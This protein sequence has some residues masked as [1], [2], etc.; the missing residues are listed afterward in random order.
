M[1]IERARVKHK[2]QRVEIC[3]RQSMALPRRFGIEAVAWGW[4]S[5][6][7]HHWFLSA[8]KD[9]SRQNT[10]FIWTHWNVSLACQLA[11][12]WLLLQTA[13]PSVMSQRDVTP[14]TGLGQSVCVD[15]TLHCSRFIFGH[16]RSAVL[17]GSWKQRAIF[18]KWFFCAWWCTAR[19][20]DKTINGTNMGASKS[21][22]QLR[23]RTRIFCSWSTLW[24]A[25]LCPLISAI[26]SPSCSDP[27]QRTWGK[28]YKLKWG[29]LSA[30]A[31]A[32]I[33]WQK[34][35]TSIEIFEV[36]LAQNT[37]CTIHLHQNLRSWNR[38]QLGYSI[39]CCVTSVYMRHSVIVIKN[40]IKSIC[41]LLPCLWIMPPCRILATVHLCLS[42]SLR[43]T[44]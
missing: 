18:W 26:S 14:L 43:V 19:A 23:W 39:C 16:F 36:A 31:K 20:L 10:W 40:E 6:W 41:A 4:S 44:P 33:F 5:W 30:S 25:T 35:I 7:R 17:T 34:N 37:C 2:T 28:C 29:P 21:S 22:L 38:L 8:G 13:H 24:F 3:N 42:F 11:H 15:L 9:D 32:R 12:H 27:A 1:L